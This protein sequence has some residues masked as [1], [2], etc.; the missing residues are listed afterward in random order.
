M[1]ERVWA[2][3]NRWTFKIKPIAELLKQE[4]EGNMFGWIDPFCGKYSPAA[5]SERNDIDPEMD[6]QYHMDALEFLKM[7]ANR[8][9]DGVLYDPPYSITQARKYGKKEYANKKYWASCKDEIARITRPG[10]KVI[11]FGW[12]S[13]G[14]GKKRGFELQRVL[15]VAHGG[16]R[17]DTIVTVEQKKQFND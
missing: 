14:I 13:N 5:H 1:L 15:L 4:M 17:N 6:A 9:A 16:N 3:P 10:G 7:W 8:A 12:S 11:C 2:M